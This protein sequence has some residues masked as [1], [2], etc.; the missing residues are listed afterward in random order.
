[1]ILS[2]NYLTGQGV[3]RCDLCV[4]AASQ[5]QVINF[6]DLRTDRAGLIFF[7]KVELVSKPQIMFEDKA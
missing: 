4:F 1:M 6:H 7:S 5:G 2:S 3:R